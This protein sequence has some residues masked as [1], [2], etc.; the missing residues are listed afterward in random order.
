MLLASYILPSTGDFSPFME[1]N[2][3][4]SVLYYAGLVARG[5]GLDRET[6]EILRKADWEAIGKELLA[7]AEYCAWKYTWSHSGHSN[8]AAGQT[9]ED[10]VQE[11]I[12]KTLE[13]VRKWDP[14]KGPLVPWLRDQVKSLVEHLYQSAAHRHE[15]PIPETDNGEELS[16]QIQYRASQANVHFPAGPATPERIMLKR[17]EIEQRETVLFQAVEGDSE[18][19]D[20][21]E[22]LMGGCEPRARHIAEELGVPVEDIY[23]RLRRLKRRISRLMQGENS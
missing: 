16:D 19:E 21:V 7:F 9:T 6:F 22:A 3:V 18:L 4:L 13:G 17:E 10:I 8:L 11:V 14:A 15:R 5:S 1:K 20:V 12:V 23:N 2:L